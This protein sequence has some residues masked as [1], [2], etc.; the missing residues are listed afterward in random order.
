MGLRLPRKKKR[1]EDPSNWSQGVTALTCVAS[2]GRENDTTLK[3][4]RLDD[5][6]MPLTQ[7]KKRYPSKLVTWD[8]LRA[9]HR[10]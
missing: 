10:K 6:W 1:S 4:L 7:K 2:G 5:A 8:M 9:V 3:P